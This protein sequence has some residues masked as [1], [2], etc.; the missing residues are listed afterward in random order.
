MIAESISLTGKCSLQTVVSLINQ[1]PNR[2]RGFTLVE[3]MVVLVIL[4]LLSGV[5]TFSIQTYLIKSKQNIAKL[6]IGKMIQALDS[7]YVSIGRYPSN[8]E[9]I[10]I[11]AAKTDDAPQGLLTFVPSDPWGHQYEYRSPGAEDPYE[12]I[13]FGADKREGGTGGDKDIT[14]MD[15]T[16]GKKSP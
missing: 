5:V 13:C 10:S 8:E 2:L 14:S 3:L 7:F 16:R 15:L 4:S 1:R 11:L 12:I 9:G 6:E